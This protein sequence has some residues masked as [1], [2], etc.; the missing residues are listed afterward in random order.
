MATLALLPIGA[1]IGGAWAAS[2]GVSATA[3]VFAGMTATAL[4]AAIGSTIGGVIDSMVVYPALFGTG[5][6]QSGAKLDSLKVNLTTEGS[7]ISRVFG[8]ECRV[9]GVIDWAPKLI[10]EQAESS[11]GGKHGGQQ[12]WKYFANVGIKF[13][14]CPRSPIVRFRKI[15]AS[16]KLIWDDGE[17]VGDEVEITSTELSIHRHIVSG[18]PEQNRI[19]I[20]SVEDGPNLQQFDGRA[21]TVSGFTNSV[22]NRTY[23]VVRS[24]DE[25]GV[26]R[27]ECQWDPE[28]VN[29]AAGASVTIN[30]QGTSEDATFDSLTTYLGTSGEDPDPTME[31]IEGSGCVPGYR[32]QARVVINRLNLR[33]WGNA[34]PTFQAL[35]EESTERSVASVISDILLDHG[36][37]VDDFDVSAVTGNCRGYVVLGNSTGVKAIEPLLMAYDVGVRESN[38]KLVFFMRVDAP[39]IDVVPADLGAAEFGSDATITQFQ[40]ISDLQLP[41]MVSVSVYEPARNWNRGT[42][43]A[44]RRVFAKESGQVIDL[45]VTMTGTEAHAVASRLLW[46]AWVGRRT[47]VM[48]LPPSYI[49][50][51]PQ[52]FLTITVG[53]RSYK[54]RVEVINEGANYRIEASGRV[55]QTQA[56]IHAGLSEDPLGVTDQSVYTPPPASAVI[57]DIPAIAESHASITGY[58][59][60]TFA[61]NPS[62]QWNGATM[63]VSTDGTSFSTVGDLPSELTGGS[64]LGELGEA[65]P[66]VWDMVNELEIE[67]LHG[68]ISTRPEIDVLNGANMIV[69]GAEVLAFCNASFLGNGKWK[70]SKLLRGL[71]DTVAEISIHEAGEPVAMLS[72]SPLGLAEIPFASLAQPRMWRSVADGGLITSAITTERTLTGRTVK[73]FAPC[74]INGARDVSNNLT[75]SWIRR[76]RAFPRLFSCLQPALLEETEIYQVEIMSGSTVLRTIDVA[77]FSEVVYSAA[78]QTSDGLTPGD[79]V[80]VRVYQLS[81][82]YGRGNFKEA[83]V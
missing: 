14:Y 62:S 1:Y 80:T 63:H 74:H 35:L 82:A 43:L 75:I 61:L 21:I 12:Y 60:G 25:D 5:V 57:L 37:T 34:M 52:D 77:T 6:N 66:G 11:G 68:T 38:G 17:D 53:A 49:H 18:A 72:G 56:A 36:L 3:T 23:E 54:V 22:N 45:P 29:E 70:I 65:S 10:P 26:T 44:K 13:A 48:A 33:R 47:V 28:V 8:P 19:Y 24:T 9:A 30:Q 46:E 64:A 32:Y 79:P 59:Y 40:D 58:Y 2:A 27:L 39:T 50:I 4:G 69:V 83:T 76:S 20:L 73:S 16:N 41:A 78:Q 31:S 51:E 71:R 15:W 67:L 55:V 7:P 81:V 42:H